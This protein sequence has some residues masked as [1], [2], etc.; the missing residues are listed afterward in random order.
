MSFIQHEF[1]RL[2]KG[3][4]AQL[5]CNSYRYKPYRYLK[6]VM[7]SRNEQW[8]CLEYFVL[9]TFLHLLPSEMADGM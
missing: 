3:S 2:L 8:P 4:V 9:G 7:F 6:I 1:H 5:K